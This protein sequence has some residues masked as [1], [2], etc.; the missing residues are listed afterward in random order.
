[1]NKLAAAIVA[2]AAISL[3]CGAY[4]ADK[5]VISDSE[6]SREMMNF[7]GANSEAKA[8]VLEKMGELCPKQESQEYKDACFD[9]F[10]ALESIRAAL[11]M[12]AK[13]NV[14]ALKLQSSASKPDRSRHFDLAF[15]PDHLKQMAEQ[16][17]KSYAEIVEIYRLK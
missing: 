3:S 8:Q 10:K 9:A 12:I 4:A 5:K 13:A 2:L 14:S 7:R 1:M 15:R 11:G 16:V 6:F 17:D